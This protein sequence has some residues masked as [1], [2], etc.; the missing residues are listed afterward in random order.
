MAR[1]L[2][3]IV[4]HPPTQST[5]IIIELTADPDVTDSE[6]ITLAVPYSSIGGW[7][8]EQIE[9]SARTYLGRDDIHAHW[10]DDVSISIAVGDEPEVWPEDIEGA[11]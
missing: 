5:A 6:P 7:S 10:N 4:T 9:T 11:K 3:R 1:A 8:E 2:R